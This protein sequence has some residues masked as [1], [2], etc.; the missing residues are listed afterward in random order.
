MATLVEAK[1][2]LRGTNG[3]AVETA[4]RELGWVEEVCADERDEAHALA[5]Q[6]SDG[7]RSLLLAEDVVVVDPEQH[8]IVVRPE[9]SLLEL[10]TSD[11][12]VGDQDGSASRLAASWATG[13]VIN[14]PSHPRSQ[15]MRLVRREPCAAPPQA[16]ERPL[17]QVVLALY[18]SLALIAALAITLAF[19]VARLVTGVAY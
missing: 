8:R 18:A 5:V 19:V 12:M 10:D 7:R 3:F 6:T 16:S 1:A 2:Q 13:A 14:V 9:P 17:W 4:D 11:L 15:R